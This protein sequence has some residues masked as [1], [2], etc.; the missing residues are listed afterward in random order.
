MKPVAL[1]TTATTDGTKVAD[2]YLIRRRPW[3]RRIKLLGDSSP[4]IEWPN[5]PLPLAQPGTIVFARD[6]PSL[7]LAD[8]R[9]AL[10][11]HRDLWDAVQHEFWTALFAGPATAVRFE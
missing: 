9:A 7:D 2:W 4:A 5:T 6:I 10:P 11:Q 3:I 8:A 1:H